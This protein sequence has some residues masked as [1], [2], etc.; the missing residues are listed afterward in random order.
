MVNQL[1]Q[2]KPK[3]LCRY[4]GCFTPVKNKRRVYCSRECHEKEIGA[5]IPK[6]GNPACAKRVKRG[7]NQFCSWECYTV[8]NSKDAH[9]NCQRVGCNEPLISRKSTRKYCSQECYRIDHPNRPSRK[10]QRLC[11]LPGCGNVITRRGTGRK[12]CSVKCSVKARKTLKN[13][14]CPTCDTMF[15]PK[16]NRQIFCSDNCRKSKSEFTLKK[17][18]KMIRRFTR[19][20]DETTN[21][22]KLV[23]SSNI[24]W[25]KVHGK[26]HEGYNVWFKDENTFNDLEINNLY[27]VEHKEY[28]KL[29]EKVIQHDNETFT[30]GGYEGRT[31]T[32]NVKKQYFNHKAELF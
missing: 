2:T 26:I 29:V 8:V 4:E 9:T 1:E 19:V 25:E 28:L 32:D 27:L 14:S 18:G 13:I 21:T 5:S 30:S 3:G 22:K 31:E 16:R 12:F 23:L 6:C 15:A 20:L 24:V 17:H 11:T 10:K 7:R